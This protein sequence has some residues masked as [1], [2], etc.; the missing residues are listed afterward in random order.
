[1]RTLITSAFIMFVSDTKRDSP[2]EPTKCIHSCKDK[3]E[4]AGVVISNAKIS[5]HP[6]R[7]AVHRR[8]NVDTAEA[9][10]NHKDAKCRVTKMTATGCHTKIAR[11]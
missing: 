4:L 9:P 7:P 1:M 5:Y 6:S 10:K 8:E 3:T 11:I 2:K